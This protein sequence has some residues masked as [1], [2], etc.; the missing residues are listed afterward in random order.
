MIILKV[1]LIAFTVINF[2]MMTM[3][4][5]KND[6]RNEIVNASMMLLTFIAATSI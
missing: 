5:H 2:F 3:N 1:I 4:A 6:I